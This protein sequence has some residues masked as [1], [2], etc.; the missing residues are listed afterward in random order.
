M[1]ITEC[2]LI[3]HF[4]QKFI[5]EHFSVFQCGIFFAGR[6][7]NRRQVGLRGGRVFET[8]KGRNGKFKVS[9]PNL[10]SY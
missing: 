7:F 5:A 6:P 1:N 2:G 10:C 3:I 8:G 9:F 4:T